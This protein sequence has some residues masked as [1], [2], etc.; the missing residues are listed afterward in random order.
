MHEDGRIRLDEHFL[1]IRRWRGERKVPATGIELDIGGPFK[2]GITPD[3]GEQLLS[4]LRDH[5]GF[6]HP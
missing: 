6:A 4:E 5:P 1:T 3:D 2:I